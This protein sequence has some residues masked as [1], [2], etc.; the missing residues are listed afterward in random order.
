MIGWILWIAAGGVVALALLAPLESLRWWSRS[1]YRM[2]GG[3]LESPHSD[4]GT[5]TPSRSTAEHFV[6]YLSGVGTISGDS[7]SKTEN[8]FLANLAE[9]VPGVE[10]IT[11]VFPYS[12]R[13]Y[14]LTQRT[15]RRVWTRLAQARR[16]SA[17]RMLSF[18]INLRNA[19]QVFVSAD[20]RYG[21]TYN[22]GVG[23]V[24]W[25]CLKERGYT[26]GCGVPVTIIGYS[27]GA[28]VAI[29]ASWYLEAAGIL[30]SVISLGGV[31]AETPGL[32]RVHH[33]Y[34]LYGSKD[35]LQRLGGIL[36]PGRWPT[37]TH[38]AYHRAV[39]DG[40]IG[41]HEIGPMKHDTARWYLDHRAT[42]PDGRSY[43]QMTEDAV[44][45][46]LASIPRR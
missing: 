8:R 44:V 43:F 26:P 16:L 10:V 33:V 31:F 37:S 41:F 9:R 35:V 11:D 7:N 3:L 14:A 36:S 40:R 17:T 30:V 4:D 34:H 39:A 6:V 18:V 45:E 24:I 22:L 1:G 20:P 13:N 46:I 23:Q 2:A 28:Q 38:S 12:V 21:P 5:T 19:F 42:G 32:D 27:G 25:D 29:G 15:A